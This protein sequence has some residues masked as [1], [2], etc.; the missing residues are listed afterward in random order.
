MQF[1]VSVIIPVF[2]VQDFIEKAVRSALQQPEVAEVVVVND[3]STDNSLK[4]L[5][6]LQEEDV[7]VKIHHHKNGIN[8]GRSASRNLGISNAKSDYVAFLDADDFY[9][10]SRFENDKDIFKSDKDIDGVYNAIGAHFYRKT[11]KLEKEKLKLTTVN[12][13]IKPETLFDTLLFGTNGHFSIDGLT[14]KKTIFDTVGYFTESLLIS[15]DTEL[16]F[17]MALKAQLKSGIINKPVAMR[18]VH[19][20][21]IFNREDLYKKYRVKMYESLFSWCNKN[22]ISTKKRDK[23]LD[24][25]WVLKYRQK[26]NLLHYIIYWTDVFFRNPKSLFSI[27]SIKYFPIIRLRQKLFPFLYKQ[28]QF[29]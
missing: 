14:V 6:A 25:L 8:K 10:E 5:E 16:I 24:K 15:E 18:G 21:N 13:R 12:R 9:L 4:I 2:N 1:L 27:L 11:N 26:K 23:L 22:N 28:K 29:S 19:D 20:V 7:R 3:G 17:K